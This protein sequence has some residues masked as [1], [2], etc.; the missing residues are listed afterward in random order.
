MSH[1]HDHGAGASTNAFRVGVILNLAFVLIEVI[2]GLAAH[3][4][5]LLAD[6]G[7]NLSDVLGLG[8]A[9]GA[10]EMSRRKPTPRRTYG[11]RRSTILAA[12]A[13]AVLLLVAIGAIGWE[14]VQRLLQPHPVEGLTVAIVAGA[15][16]AVNGVTAMLFMRGRAD[17]LNVRGAFL[18]MIA[19]AAVSAAV[20]LAGLGMR[21]TGWTWLDP[22]TSLAVAAVILVGTWGLLRESFALAMDAV[23][24][25]IDPHEVRTYLRGLTGVAAVHD[26]HIW[27]MST[28]EAALTAH[29]V[30]GENWADATLSGIRD[31]LHRR[32]GIE[33]V[34]IQVERE[35]HGPCAQEPESVV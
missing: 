34:T 2:A 35:E 19:D 14:A 24:E 33:H 31:D 20:V 28:T 26:L 4:L 12:L 6:A 22:L 29:L 3:S 30:C 1:S 11:L 27:A 8:L 16:V 10:A 7:H 9:W 32:F 5:A 13:N 23:P 17:D 21:W 18:H 15:G 25:G